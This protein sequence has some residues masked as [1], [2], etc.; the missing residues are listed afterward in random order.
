MKIWYKRLLLSINLIL[1][2]VL[3]ALWISIPDTLALNIP[4]TLFN[5]ALTALV[6]I[7]YR[8][9]LKKYYQTEHFKKLTEALIFVILVFFLGSL[10][11][12]WSYKHPLQLDLSQFKMNSLSDQSKNVLK[13]I[14]DEVKFT[15]FA[16]KQESLMWATLIEYYRMEKNNI[17]VEKIDIDVR[18]D[19]VS[20]YHLTEAATLVVEYHG[21]RQYV[22]ERDELNITNALIKISRSNDPVIYFVTGHGEGAFDSKEA[23]GLK[24]IYEAMKSSALEIR[25]LNLLSA[26]TIPF[27]AKALIILGPRTAFLSSEINVLD[28]FM[29]RGGRLLIG[30]DPDLNGDMHKPL[31]NFL[32][33]YNLLLRN[34][35]VVDKKSFVNGSEGSIPLFDTFNSDHPITKK[36]KGQ[37]FFPLCSS[38]EKKLQNSDKSI[39]FLM[40]TSDFP[41]S[42]GETSVA[43]IAKK[44]IKFDKGQDTPGPLNVVAAYES[45]QNKIVLFG[46]ST[47]VLNAYLKFGANYTLFLNAISWLVDEDRLISFNLPIVQSEPIFISAPQ[48]GIVFYFSVIFTPLILFATAIFIYRRKRDR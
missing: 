23:E 38:I 16:R 46:N 12:Y 33:K 13:N 24:F 9:P 28:S 6:I 7:V 35:L 47:F 34:D 20:D 15:I 27:D 19:L 31:K 29:Q 39:S 25:P 4:V 17:Q 2:L 36:F 1:Y 48:I 37:V 18:P 41:A 43:Q 8:E 3:I 32:L 42:W 44:E 10:A 14:K 5:L 22:T 26:Q 40:S 45:A 21:R 30:L 11:N